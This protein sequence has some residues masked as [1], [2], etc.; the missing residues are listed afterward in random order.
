[1][2]EVAHDLREQMFQFVFF[3]LN[4][5]VAC[6]VVHGA[7]PVCRILCCSGSDC[8]PDVTSLGNSGL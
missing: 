5:H 7:S 1:M 8:L 3:K 2:G 6:G 4:N